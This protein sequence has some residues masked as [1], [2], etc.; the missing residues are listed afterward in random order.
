M[1]G[2][3]S[4]DAEPTHSATTEVLRGREWPEDDPSDEREESVDFAELWRLGHKR[5]WWQWNIL[6][7]FGALFVLAWVRELVGL[8]PAATWVSALAVGGLWAFAPVHSLRLKKFSFLREC[9]ILA[10]CYLALWAII[11]TSWQLP[12]VGGMVRAVAMVT[13][14]VISALAGAAAERRRRDA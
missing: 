7:L 8:A 6:T 14:I 12:G 1:A 5:P 9:V 10:P 2:S 13:L 3:A 4:N 11:E